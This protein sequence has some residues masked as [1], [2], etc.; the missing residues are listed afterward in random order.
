VPLPTGL[1]FK[2]DWSRSPLIRL[3][4]RCLLNFLLVPVTKR[5]SSLSVG[6]AENLRSDASYI[7]TAN[8]VSHLDTLLV[9]S[10][11]P[12]RH[13]RRTVVAA[14][15][16]TF[17][18]NYFKGVATALSFNAIPIDRHKVN[19][20]SSDSAL[21]LLAKGWS[22]LIY[23][24]G[25]RTTTGSLMEFKA[26]ASFM[27]ERSGVPVVPTYIH[28]AGLLRGTQYAKAEIFTQAPHRKRHHVTVVF[29]SPLTMLDG[30]NLRRFNVRIHDAVAELERELLSGTSIPKD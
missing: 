13:R 30:E 6:G 7:F 26:G 25:G 22:L 19:R 28:E 14:A 2:T 29:G 15:M 27:A 18:M 1:D 23:P 10:A 12:E 20:R 4:R 21:A 5:V 17:F 3:V 9:L 8:H 11:L 24:E 16:D